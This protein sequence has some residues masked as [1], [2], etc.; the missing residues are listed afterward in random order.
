MIAPTFAYDRPL[1]EDERWLVDHVSMWGS[2]GYPV[3]KRGNHWSWDCRSL[4]SPTVY[5]TKREATAAF[6]AYLDVLHSCKA[7]ESY[8]AALAER[9]LVE[10]GGVIYDAS[11]ED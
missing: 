8:R 1:T 2:D 4:K 11:E 6:E 9:G 3:R 7:A 5:K 10:I